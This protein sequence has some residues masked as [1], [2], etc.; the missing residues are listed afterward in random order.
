[1]EIASAPDIFQEVMIKLL[2]GLDYVT[3]YIDDLLIIQKEDEP[4]EFHL[5]KLGAVLGQLEKRG[6]KANLKKS[7]FMQEEIKYLEYMLT[8]AR[9]KSKPKKV[10]AMLRM[11]PPKNWR[12]IECFLGMVNYYRDM[13]EKRS[14]I[15]APLNDLAGS[16]KKKDWQ[17]TEV[18]QA[19]FGEAKA[20]LAQEAILNYPYFSK[21]FVIHSDASDLQLDAVISQDGI[22]LAYYTRRKLNSTQ[23]NY[24]VGEK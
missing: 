20:M 6:F 11:Q 15:L 22:P 2:G 14:H 1:M 9:I 3:V 4:D 17:W 8:R 10:E 18:E 12:Q 24:I 19:A 5:E 13:W 16:K 21:P 23:K 7:F